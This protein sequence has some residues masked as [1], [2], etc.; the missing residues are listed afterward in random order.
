MPDSERQRRLEELHSAALQRDAGEREG[1][2]RQAA[3]E[4]RNCAAQSN[5]CWATNSSWTVFWKYR[6]CKRSPKTL[7]SLSSDHKWATRWGRI[8]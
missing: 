6:H 8:I 4:M 1:F 7:R 2:L 5:R 3:P